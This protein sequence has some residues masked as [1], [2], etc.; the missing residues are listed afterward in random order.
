MP[1]SSSCFLPQMLL[2]SLRFCSQDYW[3]YY[4]VHL[5]LNSHSFLLNIYVANMWAKI[6]ISCSEPVPGTH[7]N[8]NSTQGNSVSFMCDCLSQYP[9]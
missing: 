8:G 2:F 7:N 4:C 5:F 3:P 9:L 1:A 6:A